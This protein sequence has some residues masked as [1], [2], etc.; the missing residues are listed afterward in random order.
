MTDRNP[1]LTTLYVIRSIG[2]WRPTA[3]WLTDHY[4]ISDRTLK[5][6]L[7]E[8]QQLGAELR[9]VKLNDGRY[10]WEC[11]NWERLE[12]TGR[13]DRWIDLEETRSLT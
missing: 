2:T 12:A 10:H 11:A 4:E 9:P 7:A 6:H 5:R 1:L 8:A 3:A 13:L